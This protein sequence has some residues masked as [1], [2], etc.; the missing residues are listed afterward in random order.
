VVEMLLHAVPALATL[1]FSEP[2][3]ESFCCRAMA[4][5]CCNRCCCCCCLCCCVRVLLLLASLGVWQRVW[6]AV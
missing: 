5:A 4:R 6:L 3:S 2:E 1:L